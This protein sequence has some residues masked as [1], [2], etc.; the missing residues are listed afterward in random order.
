[1]LSIFLLDKCVLLQKNFQFYW[2]KKS[3]DFK[4]FNDSI[5]KRLIIMKTTKELKKM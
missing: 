3:K 5:K 2:L 4:D 1:M